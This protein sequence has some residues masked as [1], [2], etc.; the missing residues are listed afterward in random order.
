MLLTKFIACQ[1]PD[2]INC[3]RVVRVTPWLPSFEWDDSSKGRVPWVKLLIWTIFT[4]CWVKHLS[5]KKI[6]FSWKQTLKSNLFDKT[7]R[8]IFKFSII[9]QKTWPLE[10]KWHHL[11]PR[12]APTMSCIYR[13][14]DSS[15]ETTIAKSKYQS[16]FYDLVINVSS[17]SCNL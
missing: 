6:L 4:W 8:S 3:K 1:V 9:T 17:F 14:R 11:L 12:H 10:L 16:F 5:I 7:T 15:D 13:L 2:Y